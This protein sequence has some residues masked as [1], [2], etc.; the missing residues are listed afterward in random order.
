MSSPALS[1]FGC[2]PVGACNEVNPLLKRRGL[3]GRKWLLERH[4]ELLSLED[5]VVE[6]APWPIVNIPRLIGTA[7]PES[8]HSL[9][10][11]FK[12]GEFPHSIP[13]EEAKGEVAPVKDPV[14]NEGVGVDTTGA[15]I[16][17]G[18]GPR[19]AA[20]KGAKVRAG[21]QLLRAQ[22]QE[23]G[24]HVAF[25]E[26][27]A[28]ETKIIER[29]HNGHLGKIEV[30]LACKGGFDYLKGQLPPKLLLK[31][32]CF[33]YPSQVATCLDIPR[34]LKVQG[35]LGIVQ[36]DEVE[37]FEG[38]EEVVGE[39]LDNEADPSSPEN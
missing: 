13:E 20:R 34:V 31:E 10:K 37:A 32:D 19:D 30:A 16:E 26:S 39:G 15:S 14:G 18:I 17:T 7:A 12:K 21:A 28:Y 35:G 29:Y 24:T 6:D 2:Q 5:E 9:P 38:E 36:E 33:K 23:L 11:F 8:P 27:K 1:F 3:R 25:L 4:W 22:V